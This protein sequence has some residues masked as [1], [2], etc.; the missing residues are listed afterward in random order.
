MCIRDSRTGAYEFDLFTDTFNQML[1]EI[2]QSDARLQGQLGRMNLLQ[3]ITRATGDRQD[4]QSIF[5]VVLGSLEENLR[6]DFCCFL[7]HDPAAK[8][9]SVRTVGAAGRTFADS[10][11]ISEQSGVPIDENGLSRCIAGELVYEP[12]ATQILFPFPQKLAT[13]GL[14][15]VVM[16]PVSYTHLDVYKRQAEQRNDA[17]S[18]AV[19][20][21][22]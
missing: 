6:I 4:L 2:Q 14:R 15:S 16:A 12:D 1:T 7:I 10:L 9:L 21:Q 13:A 17:D 18:S 20:D 22:W 3:H 8:S 19:D 5:Q 11:G